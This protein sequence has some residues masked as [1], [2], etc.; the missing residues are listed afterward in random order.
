MKRTETN[1]TSN[2]E[3]I[4]ISRAEYEAMQAQ[5]AEQ[6]QL[7]DVKSAEL[8]Q[9]LLQNRWLMEQLK[10]NK[11]KLFGSSSEQLDQMVMEQFTH[12]F[13]EAEAW[14]ADSVE[15]AKKAE[16][17]K[18]RKRRSGS[19]GD[20]IPEGTPVEVVEHPLPEH[21]RVCSVCG[22]ELV[23]IGVEIHRSLQM[24][25]AEFWV[26]EDR[27]PTYVCKACEKETGE[28]NVV[29]TPMEPTVIPGSFASPS[30]IAHLAVQKY[31]MY[32]PLYRLEQEFDR[33]GL[34]LSRQTMSNW[35][36]TATEDWLQPIYNV[37]HQ[38]LRKEK[39]LHGDE[40]TL[41]VLHEKDK[42]ATSRSYMWLYRTSGDAEQPVVLYDYQPN[43]KA[44]NAEMFLDGFSGWLHA[45]GY[46]GYH[47]LPE[48]IRVVGCWAHARRKFDEALTTV[49]KEQ[50][51]ASKPA[52]ALCHFAKLF[53]MEQDF[54][55]L[56]VEE[57]FTKRLEQEKPVLEALLAWANR[58]KPQTAPKSALG[59]ALHYLLEQWPY[60]VRYLEDGRLELS[61]NRAERSIKPFVM[62][63]KN[64]LFCNTPGGAQSS[65][66]LYSLI[67]TAKET[68]LDPYRYLLW[69]LERA[70]ELAQAADEAWAE[71]LIPA[72][73]P[74]ECSASLKGRG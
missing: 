12:L 28:A 46:Q 17:K 63:R 33:Q 50:Q 5:L 60:L 44:E 13:N 32:S 20:V 66:V 42:S 31:V 49:P 51:S 48:N 65:A 71:K 55:A 6:N 74:A 54:A 11:R 18:P 26:Q 67:E 34:K 45:D 3:M 73:A 8:A 43:R 27:Y 72:E 30:A 29:S 1:E 56:T 41:Q 14:D 68:G 62:G 2:R 52:E 24:K 9:V 37:L 57:R 69:V 53:Q 70:P 39:V 4:T 10:L 15:P 59:K 19:I 61:N 35:L 22:S 58:L 16:K 36:L 21:E 38:Q 64:F 47:R 23:E 7:L 25:P 40:T